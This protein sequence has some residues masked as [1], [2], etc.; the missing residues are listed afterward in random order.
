MLSLKKL[1]GKRRLAPEEVEME[2]SL[3]SDTVQKSQFRVDTPKINGSEVGKRIS[4]LLIEAGAKG[5]HPVSSY[6]IICNQCNAQ[7]ELDYEH[8]TSGEVVG[9]KVASG[10]K[11]LETPLLCDHCGESEFRIVDRQFTFKDWLHDS[12]KNIPNCSDDPAIGFRN[13][14]TGELIRDH[15]FTPAD[16]FDILWDAVSSHVNKS[17]ILKSNFTFNYMNVPGVGTRRINR[18]TGIS[19]QNT[20]THELIVIIK[21]F[22]NRFWYRIEQE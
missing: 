19:H 16:T 5:L 13:S 22:N 17:G 9:F 20:I 1:F 14:E 3:V 4:S 12:L 21:D 2:S 15:R 7:I 10:Y 18:T 8:P 11:S 6:Q